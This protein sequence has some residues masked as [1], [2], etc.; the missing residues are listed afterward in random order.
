MRL[1]RPWWLV[2]LFWLLL[3]AVATCA[4][5]LLTGVMGVPAL[6]SFAGVIL[7]PLLITFVLLNRPKL[8][9]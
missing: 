9:H 8:K 2:L 1:M 6:L 7:L 4:W 5:F 3:V